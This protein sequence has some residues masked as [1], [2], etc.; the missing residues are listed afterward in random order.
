[1]ATC[2]MIFGLI[3]TPL[4]WILLLTATVTPQWREFAQRPGYSLDL[5]FY[6]GLWETCKEVTTFNIRECKP[7]LKEA[8]ASWWIHLQRFL[9]IISVIIGALSYVAAHI[10]VHWWDDNSMPNLTGSAGL[11]IALAGSLYICVVSYSAFEI[12]SAI[13]DSAIEVAEKFSMGT[14]LYLGWCGGFVVLISG[15]LLMCNYSCKCPARDTDL[16]Y[17]PNV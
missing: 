6:D 2:S 3:L 5:F 8:V 10:G 11:F 12:L 16:H 17:G 14:C 9:T 4:G 13:M 7:L 1:M 15:I